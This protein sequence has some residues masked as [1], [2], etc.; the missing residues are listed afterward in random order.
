MLMYGN[1]TV[2]CE[3]TVP[4][5]PGGSQSEKGARTVDGLCSFDKFANH[6]D[7]SGKIIYNKWRKGFQRGMQ[8]MAIYGILRRRRSIDLHRITG[9]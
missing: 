3:R 2:K 1:F 7:K 6:R 9:T 5:V 4:C 8:T